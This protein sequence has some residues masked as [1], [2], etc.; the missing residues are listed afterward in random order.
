MDDRIISK[1]GITSRLTDSVETAVKLAEGLVVVESDEGEELFS[2][3]YACPTCGWML[4]EISPRL[5]SP[6][7]SSTIV[8]TFVLLSIH[9]K[10]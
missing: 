1:E 9:P 6:N 7:T 10:I 4:E 3:N 2:T 5:F 8:L